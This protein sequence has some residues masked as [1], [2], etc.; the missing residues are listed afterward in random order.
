MMM[1]VQQPNPS[2]LCAGLISTIKHPTARPAS[3]C[4][5][6]PPQWASPSVMLWGAAGRRPTRLPRGGR[7]AGAKGVARACL[8][9]GAAWRPGAREASCPPPLPRTTPGRRGA[10]L[11]GQEDGT[12]ARAGIKLAKYQVRGVEGVVI[13]KVGGDQWAVC[14][15]RMPSAGLSSAPAMRLFLSPHL[16]PHLPSRPGLRG[17]EADLHVPPFR[18]LPAHLPRPQGERGPALSRGCTGQPPGRSPEPCELAAQ[19]EGQ[20]TGS[21]TISSGQ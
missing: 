13:C 10:H 5:T 11:I 17:A 8:P 20:G 12:G 15:I 14:N 18:G 19:G 7:V 4:S 3:R 1:P 16:T 21:H 6:V 9:H 2:P